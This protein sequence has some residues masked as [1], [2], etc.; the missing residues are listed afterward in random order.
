MFNTHPACRQSARQLLRQ[1]PLSL[2]L[3]A[4]LLRLPDA[5]LRLLCYS[6]KEQ[7]VRSVLLYCIG[8]SGEVTPP[9]HSRLIF[10]LFLLL[11]AFLCPAIYAAG[12]AIIRGNRPAARDFAFG[13]RHAPRAA[14]LHL[15]VYLYSLVPS[16]IRLVLGFALLNSARGLL[17]LI[18]YD[19]ACA[20]LAVWACLIP[21]SIADIRYRFVIA[22][23]EGVIRAI[24]S[25]RSD[26]RVRR[27]DL[28]VTAL[29]I[30]LWYLLCLAVQTALVLY[31]GTVGRVIA[32]LLPVPILAY[33]VTTLLLALDSETPS[34]Q[35]L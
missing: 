27:L 23:E 1:H 20:A 32:E 26:L 14:L 30:V 2:L 3:A 17:D 21:I 28:L 24:K 19:V 25:A 9:P 31:A 11:G 13:V 34:A 4:F 7:T 18:L 12:I 16:A 33:G 6:P 22:P 8:V 10:L 35:D 15:L 29:P 5:L